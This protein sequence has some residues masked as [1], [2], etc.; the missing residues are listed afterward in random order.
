MKIARIC[1]LL[2]LALLLVPWTQPATAESCLHKNLTTI[3]SITQY[4]DYHDGHVEVA[5]TFQCCADCGSAFIQK[6]NG[7]LQGHVLHMAESV[8]CEAD[9]LHV[10]VFVCADC[11][12]PVMRLYE[13]TGG[14]D[15]TRIKAS[16]GEH[17]P[18]KTVP[19]LDDWCTEDILTK[20]VQRWLLEQKAK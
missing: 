15:C 3:R 20:I 7:G 19:C 8:H 1:V 9:G 5:H 4:Q 14:A 18:V 2:L 11:L 17:P 6:T 10:Y 16:V 13:C 12:H